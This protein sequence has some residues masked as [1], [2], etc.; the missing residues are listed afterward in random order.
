M[1]CAVM[2]AILR[3]AADSRPSVLAIRADLPHWRAGG[4]AGG[5]YERQCAL[6]VPIVWTST[7]NTQLRPA[8]AQSRTAW[9]ASA[10]PQL[11]RAQAPPR[12]RRSS[13]R[14][15][16]ARPAR[17]TSQAQRCRPSR[18]THLL[19]LR[20]GMAR[21]CSG[22]A[23]PPARTGGSCAAT[24]RRR[25]WPRPLAAQAWPTGSRGSSPRLSATRISR[26]RAWRARYRLSDGYGTS[27]NPTRLS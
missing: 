16:A 4:R 21:P 2:A 13:F 18:A 12:R 1:Q 25:R 27:G 11:A 17:R 8:L 23:V 19:K 6:R 9:R 14:P 24:G 22:V 26:A 15:S 10:P 3:A 7:H 20:P 5:R